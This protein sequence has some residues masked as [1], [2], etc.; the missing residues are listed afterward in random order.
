ALAVLERLDERDT[1]AVVV[2]DDHIDVLQP[3]ASVTSALKRAV[4]DKLTGIQARAS[5]ALHQGWLTGCE[6]IA[7]AEMMPPARGVARCFLLTDGQANVGMTD[8][9][10]IAHQA[11]D[12][13]QRAHIGTSTFGI[14]EDYAEELLGPMAEAGGGRFHNLRTADE[15]A[16]TFVNELGEMLATA[17]SSVKLELE[18]ESGVIVDVLSTFW[19]EPAPDN[20]TRWTIA[21]GDLFDGEERHAVVRLGFADQS[22]REEQA[23]RARVLWTAA[24]AEHSSD[25]ADIR[26]RYA[27]DA[28]VAADPVDA[29]VIEAAGQHLADRAHREALRQSK[30]GDLAGA[31]RTLRSSHA[32]MAGYA[33]A[34]PSLGPEV[35]EMEARRLALEHGPL[36][37]RTAK[38]DYFRRQSR[39]SGKRDLRGPAPSPAG[40]PPTSANQAQRLLADYIKTTVA[41]PQA[42]PDP[43]PEASAAVLRD[44]VRGCLLWGA[45]G[46]A[47]ARPLRGQTPDAIRARY[48]PDGLTRYLPPREW[49]SGPTGAL[50]GDT[51][52]TLELAR[53]LNAQDGRLDPEEFARRLAG[54]PDLWNEV[55][56][57]TG[58]AARNIAYGQP[59]WEAADRRATG[60]GAAV[61][62]APVGLVHA[63]AASPLALRQQAVLSALPTHAAPSAVAGAVA[64]AAGVAWLL[65]EVA[66]GAEQVDAAALAGF[67]TDA[68]AGMESSAP[69]DAPT[70]ARRL[71]ELPTAIT[72]A[73][74]AEAFPDLSESSAAMDTVPL[75][76]YHFLRAPDDPRRV[77]IAAANGGHSASA[78]ASMAG[79]LAGSW[80]GAERLWRDAEAWWDGLVA[81]ADVRAL[82][83]QLAALTLR[84]GH[85]PA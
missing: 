14:G 37:S 25:W 39:S 22:R 69:G 15:I 41:W 26:F 73:T 76:F 21:I 46:D 51:K 30:S 67:V 33:M 65:R 29:T 58:L 34:S 7:S 23:V 27:D 28:A 70:L 47:L 31:Q 59:W 3:A 44:R 81:A 66:R 53:S 62:A 79:Q 19:A 84:A 75:A 16:A 57:A 20:H 11:G 78:V 32:L 2:F 45:V 12:I 85:A 6:A 77:V 55:G 48:G 80:C 54:L 5:T 72:R 40:P 52:L 61:R 83:D 4:R 17:A 35:K 42:V 8:P 64:L 56:H 9:E 1:A 43:L 38:E 13:R 24:G 82:G 50:T 36:D 18:V 60:C 49:R 63:L 68:I 10:Q 71:R 74:A